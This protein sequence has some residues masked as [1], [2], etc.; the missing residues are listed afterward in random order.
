V[1]D[2]HGCDTE[3]GSLLETLCYGENDNLVL[4]GDLVN[5]GPASAEVVHRARRERAFVVRGNHDDSGLEAYEGWMKQ[6][7]E[8]KAK[9]QWVK[10]LTREDAEW[11]REMPFT[12]SIP[13]YRLLVVF[14]CSLTICQQAMFYECCLQGVAFAASCCRALV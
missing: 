11:M 8:P 5:K 13:S 1:G 9:H 3:F 14:L 12:L 7:K 2:I 4:V 6:E 10:H